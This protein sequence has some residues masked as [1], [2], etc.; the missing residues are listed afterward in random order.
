METSHTE[1]Y[2]EQ[3]DKPCSCHGTTQ[4]RKEVLA[5]R[6]LTDLGRLLSDLGELLSEQGADSREVTL[7]DGRELPSRYELCSCR[8]REKNPCCKKDKDANN[9]YFCKT[10]K[11]CENSSQVDCG[12]HL[13]RADKKD[14][15]D[16]WHHRADPG[17][18]DKEPGDDTKYDYAC[19]CVRDS[20]RGPE[21]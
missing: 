19:I 11:P 18:P 1:D 17:Q 21:D 15:K 3:A 10:E 6:I 8:D 20:H 14:P 5:S 9:H 16:R 4:S 12:C 2:R 7:V 13:F